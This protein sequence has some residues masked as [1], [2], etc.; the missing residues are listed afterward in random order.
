VDTPGVT[1]VERLLPI[2]KLT[3]LFAERVKPPP[4]GRVDYFDATFGGLALRVTKNDHKSWSLH[5][6][7]SGRLRRF[8]IGG[9]PS[10]KPAQARREAQAAL[11]RVRL[12]FDPSEEKRQRRLAT[13]I[14]GADTFAAAVQDYLDRARRNLAHSTLKETERLL[15]REFVS[16]WRNRSISSITVTSIA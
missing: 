4:A 11:E 12:G 9:Y 10:I 16:A 3:D 6:R 14:P 8:T 5:Y 7:M 2:K 1:P 15:K 13:A